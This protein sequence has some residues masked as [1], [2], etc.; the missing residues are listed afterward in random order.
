M[1]YVSELRQG[2]NEKV[3]GYAN[4]LYD[5]LGDILTTPIDK[6]GLVVLVLGAGLSL[7]GCGEKGPKYGAKYGDLITIEGTVIEMEGQFYDGTY[8]AGRKLLIK[9]GDQLYHVGTTRESRWADVGEGDRVRVRGQHGGSCEEDF[10]FDDTFGD[11]WKG[12]YG[13]SIR[14]PRK[15]G[16][17]VIDWG[18]PD[19]R[20]VIDLVH[21]DLDVTWSMAQAERERKHAQNRNDFG[22]FTYNNHI[23]DFVD[24]LGGTV[25][26]RGWE[27]TLKRGDNP[28]KVAQKF[29]ELDREQGNL[30]LDMTRYD[31]YVM[32]DGELVNLSSNPDSSNPE[33]A[34]SLKVGE[35]IFFLD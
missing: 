1:K 30:R 12:E 31:A 2:F 25:V 8:R 28:E 19:S 15:V 24:Y 9:S 14:A 5:G 13:G 22:P 3:R 16:D 26:T 10:I 33:V 6:K 21:A 29:N 7:T 4:H 11:M 34:R 20:D 18:N 23:S 32:R 35:N 17:V 27:Y